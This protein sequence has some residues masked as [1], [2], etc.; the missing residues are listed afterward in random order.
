MVELP[1][2]ADVSVT[3]LPTLNAAL[4]GAATL[5]LTAGFLFI[6]S[7][8]QGPHRLCMLGA[9]AMSALFLASY[10]VYHLLV[11]SVPYPLRDWTRPLYFAILVPHVILA[12][13]MVPLVFAALLHA[14][15]GRYGRHR[16]VTRWL[17][18]IWMFVG[19]S[20]VAIYWMLYVHAGA[21]PTPVP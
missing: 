19:L 18:P 12:A 10:S 15:R 17:W 2:A 14:W 7:G 3:D 11:G 20:G 21:R 4:N 6:R 16:R 5:F 13:G 1:S 8:R 9:V